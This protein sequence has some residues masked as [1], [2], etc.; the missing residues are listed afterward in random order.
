MIALNSVDL[1]LPFTRRRG[2]RWCPFGI[3]KEASRQRPVAVAVGHR[4]TADANAAI[5]V[6]RSSS[7]I[8]AGLFP[9]GSLRQAFRNRFRCNAQQIDI[10]RTG[11]SASLRSRHR[12]RLVF[13]TRL[14]A[15]CSAGSG[16]MVLFGEDDGIRLA[17]TNV[18]HLA[19]PAAALALA[20]GI[21]GHD[22]APSCEIAGEIAEGALARKR[23][24]AF[25]AGILSTRRG[26]VRPRLDLLLVGLGIG[27]VD[28]GIG[29][30]CCTKA[31]EILST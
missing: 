23:A 12:A 18:D 25:S 5:L 4:S 9:E 13:C 31:C 11:P 16:E 28:L 17:R 6:L 26:W 20:G 21:D 10:G 1:P 30:S 15:T 14:R 27:L 22:K 19:H 29:G 7:R 8:G 3:S 24:I 2:P